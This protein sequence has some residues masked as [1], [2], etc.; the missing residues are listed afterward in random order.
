MFEDFRTELKKEFPQT[1]NGKNNY[2]KLAKEFVSFLNSKDGGIVYFGVEDDGTP[3][4]IGDIDNLQIA[5]NNTFTDYIKENTLG[6]FTI[7]IAYIDE[8]ACIKVSIAS[9]SNKPYYIKKYGMTEKG[10]YIRV[11]SVCNQMTQ[12][13]IDELFMSRTPY[14]LYNIKSPRQNLTFRQLK[15]Y[16]EGHR[17]VMLNDEFESTLEL[18]NDTGDY[19]YIAYLLSDTSTLSYNV[20]KFKGTD[21]IDVVDRADF[22]GS[23]IKVMDKILDKFDIYNEVEYEITH[24][25]RKER[26]LF[27]KVALREL[28]INAL[29]HNDYSNEYTPHFD[30]FDDR[31]EIT[32]NGG[33]PKGLTED[34][35]YSG[36]SRPRNREL[37]RVFK[38]LD[39]VEQLGTGVKKVLEAY[40]KDIFNISEN[41]VKIV[42]PIDGDNVKPLDDRY[43]KIM[44]YISEHGS[45]D[46]KTVEKILELKESRAKDLLRNMVKM[47]LIE[48]SEE[49]KYSYT[50]RRRILSI[51]T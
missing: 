13:M 45:I 37:I 11:G 18:R 6:L 29:V 19:N 9:G 44:D 2:E 1:S 33:L 47:N 46:R 28:V 7:T 30:V 5:I 25:V 23:L 26:Y 31:I 48:K 34:E 51:K 3:C 15:I 16:Y 27:D 22:S 36:R 39:Y 20:A 4:G 10:C 41:T 40:P 17:N 24:S 42:I 12:A 32:S 49:K 21:K 50:L 43:K 38:D 35:F 8:V 14:T